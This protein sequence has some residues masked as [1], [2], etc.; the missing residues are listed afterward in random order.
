MKWALLEDPV[1]ILL[2]DLNVNGW[3][4]SCK[5]LDEELKPY[6]I[7]RFNLSLLGKDRIVA[8]IAF[9]RNFSLHSIIHT[10]VLQRLWLMLEIMHIGQDLPT[11][12]LSYVESAKYVPK[13]M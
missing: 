3:L 2:G 6:R 1:S 4:D 8:P 5:E 10:K 12:F 11:M 9:V 7:H 13:T